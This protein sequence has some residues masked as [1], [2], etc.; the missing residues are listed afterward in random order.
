M[1]DYVLPTSILRDILSDCVLIH[2][3]IHLFN[4]KDLA[5]Y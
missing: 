4:K 3:F 1:W 5:G 2:L